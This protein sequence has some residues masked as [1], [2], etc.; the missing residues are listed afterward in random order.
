MQLEHVQLEVEDQVGVITLNR[1]EAANAQSQKVL[2]ELDQAWSTADENRDVKVIVLRSTGKH[3]SAGHDM[4]GTQSTTLDRERP[5]P[6]HSTTGRRAAICTTPRPG[7]RSRS[8][9]SPPS[10]ASASPPD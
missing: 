10:R 7:E 4:S 8:P 1:P 6:M 2:M 9:R 5:C 3:F